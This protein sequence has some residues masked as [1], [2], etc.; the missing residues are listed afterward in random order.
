MRL[1]VETDQ[2]RAK[3]AIDQLTLPGTNAEC[4]RIRPRD[5]PEDGDASVGSLLFDHSGNQRE[6]I[7]L[8]QHDRPRCAFHFLQQ[9]IGEFPVY[10]LVV[11]P[12][13]GT[14]NGPRVSDVAE[15]PEAFVSK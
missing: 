12:V 6:V 3:Q 14:K 15:R 2:V 11:A 13:V 5:M 1:H 9:S 7:V 4:L 10:G 8:Y